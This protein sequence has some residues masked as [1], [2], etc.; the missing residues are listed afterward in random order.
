MRYERLGSSGLRVSALSYGTWVTFAEQGDREQARAIL[1]AAR[2]VGINHFDTAEAY[3]GGQAEALLGS[4]LRALG[5]DRASYVL[6]TKLY[7]GTRDDVNMRR[8]LNRKY[9]L[10]AIDECLA[11]LQVRYV[12]LLY[13]HRPDPDTPIEETVWALSDIIAAGKAH[14]WGVSG[15]S[16]AQ[17]RE[18][19]E[20]AERRG[21]RRPTMV[22]PEYS[23][24]RR[25]L[26]ED[27]LAETID[28]LGLGV[29]TWS[30]LASG[31]LTGKYCR[32]EA[33]ACRACLPGYE[34]LAR[35]LLDP[36]LNERVAA[37]MGLAS[38]IGC[39]PAQLAIAWCLRQPRVSSVILGASSEQQLRHNVRAL[40]LAERLPPPLLERVGSLFPP[41]RG[42]M[43]SHH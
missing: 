27:D 23:L 35:R 14:Y 39:S 28:A 1:R 2:D 9:L 8:T 22:Q 4:T 30:P 11:R 19:W 24:V 36:A 6:A 41:T 43:Q 10:H 38:E 17:L 20:V 13:C 18:A 12:D 40:E 25:E 16:P 3:G 32:G 26:V 15:W 7:W 33:V 34:W 29:C 37:L 42:G 21:L 5:W 31:L